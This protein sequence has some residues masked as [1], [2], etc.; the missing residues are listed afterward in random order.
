MRKFLL[1]FTALLLSATAMAYDFKVGGLCYAIVGEGYSVEVTRE[2]S[3]ET[4]YQ[5]NYADLQEVVIPEFVTYNEIQY[6]VLGIGANAF[7]PAKNLEKLDFSFNDGGYHFYVKE[8]ALAGCSKLKEVDFGSV[9]E[10]GNQSFADTAIEEV[11]LNGNVKI[12]GNPFG[13]CK[14][15]AVL[16]IYKGTESNYDSRENCN[17]IIETATNTLVSG[18][19]NSTIPSTVTSIGDL[20]FYAC[21]NLAI[22]II[23]NSVT[24]IGRQAF[25]YCTNLAIE[26][27]PT[28]VVNVGAGAF[29]YTPFYPLDKEPAEGAHYIDHILY[30]Y[31][32][33]DYDTPK[34]LVVKEGT[35]GIAEYACAGI[36]F[37]SLTLPSS[38]KCISAGAFTDTQLSQLSLPAS[39]ERIE[40]YAFSNN[41]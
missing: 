11:G 27:L 4:D 32:S 23:P 36:K 17:A 13:I 16:R 15:L 35:L 38:L 28:S 5:D 33:T 37:S 24:S 41:A 1:L 18:C 10:L 2:F 7:T 12:T 26:N 6:R 39:V 22:E 19:K 29:D 20:A 31:Y 25:A 34:A 14:N 3:S 30:K 40:E 8:R 9:D 21:E